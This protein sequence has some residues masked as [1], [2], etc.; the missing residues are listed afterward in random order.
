[1]HGV[2]DRHHRGERQVAG[3]GLVDE[4]LGER[5]GLGDEGKTVARADGGAGRQ[6][7]QER[8]GEAPG[9]IEM[10]DAGA[11]WPGMVRSTR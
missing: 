5:P 3:V 8:R 4:F 10:D 6:V 11:V 1:V 7:A 9:R 2:A